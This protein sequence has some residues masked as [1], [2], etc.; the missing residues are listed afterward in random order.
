MRLCAALVLSVYTL[1]GFTGCGVVSEGVQE[2]PALS[3]VSV[4][5]EYYEDISDK[6]GRDVT[7][8]YPQL[9]GLKNI[10]LQNEINEKLRPPHYEGDDDVHGMLLEAGFRYSLIDDRILSV[11]FYRFTQYDRKTTRPFSSMNTLNVDLKTGEYLE[12]SDIVETD[13]RLKTLVETGG[14]APT[15]FERFEDIAEKDNLYGRIYS[16]YLTEDSLGVVAA[17]CA[18]AGGYV[19]LE[20]PYAEIEEL[21]S[22]EYRPFLLF[23]G[24]NKRNH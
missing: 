12:L 13:D 17:Q 4:I 9:Q 3:F 1:L 5:T 16:F 15:R 18:A 7:I 6:T 21:L 2:P 24:D 19:E 20:I 11:R 8:R 23:D 10:E 14:F 22:A